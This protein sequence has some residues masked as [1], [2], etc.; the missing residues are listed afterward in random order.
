MK[1][2]ENLLKNKKEK[3]DFSNLVFGKNFS[4]HMFTAFAI[5]KIFS[6]LAV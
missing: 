6:N 5:C 4:D 3:P 1:I 2:R